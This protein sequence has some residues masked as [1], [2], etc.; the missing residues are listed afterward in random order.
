MNR[1]VLG[2]LVTMW[3]ALAT[4]GA[5]AGQTPA[6]ATEPPIGSPAYCF[7]HSD[8]EICS[9]ASNSTI[10]V[11]GTAEIPA[12]TAVPGQAAGPAQPRPTTHAEVLVAPTC[13][14]NTAFDSTLLCGAA[15]S[16]C[17]PAGQGIYR[18]WEWLVTYRYSDNSVVSV[19]QIPGTFC[20]PPG[21]AGLPTVAAVTGQVERDFKSLVVAKGTAVTKPKGRT[22]VNFE[23]EFSTE[24]K[25]YVLAP[26]QVLGHAVVVTA[27]PAQYDWYFGDGESLLDGGNGSAG[28]V[29]HTYAKKGLVDPYVVITWSGTFTIDGGASRAVFGTAQTTGP[30][31]DLQVKQAR[32]ELV[33]G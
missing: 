13:T 17:Q 15:V 19:Q 28:D 9:R 27:T 10:I 3:M 4:L 32:A 5:A 21:V 31:T 23:T 18:Y 26:V 2:L 30:G 33:G 29:L 6:T 7:L 12:A 11:S 25:A 8:E 22:L 1:R 20:L 14:G 24:A 16:T